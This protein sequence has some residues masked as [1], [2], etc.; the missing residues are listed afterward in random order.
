M[1]EEKNIQNIRNND[2]V[3][4]ALEEQEAPMQCY[5]PASQLTDRGNVRQVGSQIEQSEAQRS[6]GMQDLEKFQK[7]GECMCLRTKGSE[8]EQDSQERWP[9]S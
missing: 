3:P 9:R 4:C 1:M 6:P 8:T 5:V 7:Q 2:T